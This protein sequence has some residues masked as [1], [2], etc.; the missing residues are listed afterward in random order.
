MALDKDREKAFKL[1]S[2]VGARKEALDHLWWVEKEF[3]NLAKTASAPL[4]HHVHDP[5][6]CYI[7]LDI[8]SQFLPPEKEECQTCRIQ[9]DNLHET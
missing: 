5:S 6:G 9:V 4:D 8:P 7:F 1:L 2:T 3:Y